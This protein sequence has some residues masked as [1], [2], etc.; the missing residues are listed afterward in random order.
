MLKE[1]ELKQNTLIFFVSDNGAPLKG[2]RDLPIDQ[3]GWDGSRND[4]LAGE[5]GTLLEGGIRVPFLVS[6]PD[7]L[8]AGTVYHRPV[9]SLDIA[10][11]A[12]AAAGLPADKAIDGVDLLSYLRSES[13][14]DPHEALYWRFWG[15]KAVRAGDWKLLQI[16]GGKQEL[17][18]N[19]AADLSETT[20]LL[21]QQ[22]D[23]AAQL[24]QQLAEWESQMVEPKP[25]GG[26][27]S[28]EQ[29][30]FQEKLK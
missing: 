14:G 10:A 24:R 26:L 25:R 17:L 27:S 29:A 22:P 1:Y 19:L 20:D 6:W 21:E 8:P 16:D 13:K 30:W 28:E 7:R 5:K 4:P 12:N 9:I 2:M 23:R 18:Y 15:Q 3:G 11:T